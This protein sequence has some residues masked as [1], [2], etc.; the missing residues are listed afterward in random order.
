M[1]VWVLLPDWFGCEPLDTHLPTVPEPVPRG[2]PVSCTSVISASGFDTSFRRYCQVLPVLRQSVNPEVGIPETTQLEGMENW[3]VE[4]SSMWVHTFVISS[5]LFFNVVNYFI[6][7]PTYKNGC[8]E[9]RLRCQVWYFCDL[10]QWS[11]TIPIWLCLSHCVPIQVD[12]CWVH[13]LLDA[14][15]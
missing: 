1:F 7:N 12:A 4:T 2:V 14:N 13:H 9:F 5:L 8:G 11:D 15:V 3:N 10:C 6:D